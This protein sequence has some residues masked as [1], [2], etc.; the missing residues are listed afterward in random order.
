MPELPHFA[1]AL[2][3]WTNNH[4]HIS[5]RTI[6]IEAGTSNLSQYRAGTRAVTFDVISK[7]LPAIERHS[8]RPAAVTL[9]IAY[10]TD[11]TPASHAT[12]IRIQ[13]VD[14]SGQTTPDT[15]ARLSRAWEAKART[16]PEFMAMWEGLDAYMH[17]PDTLARTSH[18]E[19]TIALLAEPTTH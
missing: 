14:P 3:T 8:S 2:Q 16:D 18:P 11:E 12:S 10:L 15:Y 17:T 9:L 5:L 4:P 19:S 13:P 1:A 6:A 7:L